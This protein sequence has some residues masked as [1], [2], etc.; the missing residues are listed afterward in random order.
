MCW[1]GYC[2]EKNKGDLPDKLA[3]PALRALLNAKIYNLAQLAKRSEAEVLALHGMGPNA[4]K[5]LRGALK[6]KKLAFKK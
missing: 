5:L 2:R 4:V 1:T 3:A 6:A